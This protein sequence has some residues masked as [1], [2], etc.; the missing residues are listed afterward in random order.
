[1]ATAF[2]RDCGA[3]TGYSPQVSLRKTGRRM[4]STGNVFIGDHSNQIDISW[5]SPTQLVV[6]S[7]CTKV[8]KHITDFDGIE[9]R[10]TNALPRV[11]G[12]P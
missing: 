6:H 11:A 7:D 2:V 9:V 1:M 10:F 4:H 5:T 3:T 12:N 8:F